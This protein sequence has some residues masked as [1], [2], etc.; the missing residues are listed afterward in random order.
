MGPV[1]DAIRTKEKQEAKQHEQLIK[2]RKK[3]LNR[4]EHLEQIE[5]RKKYVS[6]QPL[7]D[8]KDE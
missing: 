1:K 6:M 8:Q 2:D 5:L 7:S 3:E 4:L